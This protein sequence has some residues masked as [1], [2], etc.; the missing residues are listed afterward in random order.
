MDLAAAQELLKRQFGFDQFRQGQAE[1]IGHLLAGRSS[2]AVFPT[3]GGKSLCYQLPAQL[4][5]GLTLVV[6]PLIALMKDQIDALKRR[7]VA[8]ERLDSTLTTEEF[9]AVVQ[10]VREGRLKLLYVAPERFNN[11]RFRESMARTKIAMFAVDEAH[12]ISEW[13]HSFRPDYLKLARFAKD[14]RA[15]R[16]LALTATA[17]PQVLADVCREFSIM[18]ACAVRTGFYRPNLTLVTTP[19]AAAERDAL[20]VNR[21]RESPPGPTI[22]YVTLQ[23][24]AETVAKQLADAG[25]PARPY[26]A[27]MEDDERATVQDWFMHSSSGIVV[28]TIA[29]GMGVDKANIR[30]VY[31][32][33]LPKSLE[34]YSQEIGRAGRDGQKSTCE[35]LACP[36]DLCSLENFAHGDTPSRESVGGLLAEVFA[37]PGDFDVSTYELAGH[38]D[39]RILVVQTLLTYLELEG[40]LQ[41][42]TPFYSRY[43]FLPLKSSGEILSRFEGERREFL[44]NVLRQ[45][46]KAKT[47]CH[48]DLDQAAT[49]IGQP[50]DRVLR[51]IDYLAEQRLIDLRAEGARQT[52]RLLKKPA[53][54][55]ALGD[56]LHRRLLERER[57]EI[58]RLQQVL[59]LAGHDGCQVALL[60][61]HFGEKLPRPCGHCSWC[62]KGRRPV[63]LLARREAP[64]DEAVWRRAASL[65]AEKREVLGEP[66]ALARFLCGLTSPRLS[67]AKLGSNPLFGAFS[68]VPFAK[69][70]VR[71]E[72][73]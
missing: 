10:G 42:G 17:T 19:I 43:K 45:S 37:H 64:L 7:G 66:R 5:S 23:R 4:F 25:L 22:V 16:V 24:T 47:W 15:E 61:E 54:L 41:A 1:V 26:H 72:R 14:Y 58:D 70:L 8:A 39:I 34:N 40:Y 32:Y 3:G 33:N 53:D 51:A 60:A 20:L 62:T 31:H 28:A 2:A 55:R 65:A 13:G 59:G 68:D 57:R 38:H 29:F 36:D 49:A 27:G 67:A 56:D 11:E 6:S 21:L 18:P 50:R 46:H 63:K 12:C 44:A 35:M 73:R 9:S 52:Y 30:Y 69:V 48:I 71:A